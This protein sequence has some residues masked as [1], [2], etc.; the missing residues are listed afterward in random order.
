MTLALGSL[1]TGFSSALNHFL[2]V[3]LKQKPNRWQ[4]DSGPGFGW[5]LGAA[6]LSIATSCWLVCL[7]RLGHF[8][9][10]VALLGVMRLGTSF[11]DRLCGWPFF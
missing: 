7:E 10:L 11:P 3:A 4:G 5:R 2:G 1:T 8:L 9:A 6:M